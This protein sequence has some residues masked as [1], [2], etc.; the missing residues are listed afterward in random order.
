[1][2]RAKTILAKGAWH[3]KDA[4]G[5]VLLTYGERYRRRI[6]LTD[7]EGGELLLDLEKTRLLQDGDGLLL[8]GGKIVLVRAADEPVADISA[9]TPAAIARL[10]WHIGNR[11][12]P[13][14][15]L[16]DGSLRIR[17]D[18]VL[19]KM[20]EGLGGTVTFKHAPF[21][22]EPGAHGQIKDGHD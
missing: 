18:G 15:I 11:R 9:A 2:R 7:T 22:P 6:M 21:S 1:M 19:A 12:T 14:Q 13:L 8:D 3:E 10:A 20:A 17:N 5:I 16:P 4:V